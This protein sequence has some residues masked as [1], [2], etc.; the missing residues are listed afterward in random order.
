MKR[1]NET[2][3]KRKFLSRSEWA[4]TYKAIHSKTE[5]IVIVTL[6][7]NRS[8]DEEYIKNLSREVNLLKK[9]NNPNLVHIHD[10]F[11][12][13]AYD[14]NYYYIESEYFKSITLE[15]KLNE[16]NFSERESIK[17]L[18]EIA[19]VVNE[20]HEREEEFG[21]ISPKNILIDS[22]NTV[23]L[24]TLSYLQN[25]DF[26]INI[27]SENSEKNIEEVFNPKNDINSLG[28]ILYSLLS[29]KSIFD[30][31]NLK[32][33]INDKNLLR[34]IEKSTYSDLE[35][36]YKTVKRMIVDLESY[37]LCGQIKD[38]SY[39]IEPAVAPKSK[40]KKP[41]KV[42]KEKVKKEKK[43]KDSK[44][45]K[46]SKKPKKD[47]KV[48]ES[49]KIKAVKNL[50]EEN[51]DNNS[52]DSKKSK[53]GKTL[54]T[55]AA[56]ALIAGAGIY[57]YD[58]MQKP[59]EE[60]QA[61]QIEE[62]IKIEEEQVQE[63]VQEEIKVEEKVEE[64]VETPTNSSSN[65][66][67]NENNNNNNDNNSGTT[68]PTPDHNTGTT[69]PEGGDTSGGETTTPDTPETP[70]AP[71]TPDNSGSIDGGSTETTPETPVDE[72]Q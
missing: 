32:K 51:T 12:Y 27:L 39:D 29:G 46:E 48:K 57:A 4:D 6:L 33:D 42:E 53:L 59:E 40:N 56:I 17:I 19:T 1:F 24:N 43:Q 14:K 7:I 28:M 3:R 50:A 15:E 34:I 72:V 67:S 23:K 8:S 10:M 9:I 52:K 45:T 16:S 49:K 25:K 55:C 18:K 31:N 61:P 44:K 68:T 5:E 71:S 66:N 38:D 21:E 22:N 58:S 65:N 2:Y 26:K 47:K 20:L 69:T 64:K 70:E 54:G 41:K 37:L 13:G 36:R 62:N 60:E 11:Q 30:K 63:P 35:N